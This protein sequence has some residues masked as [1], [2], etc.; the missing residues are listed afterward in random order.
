M[1]KMYDVVRS[2]RRDVLPVVLCLAIF[3]LRG[4]SAQSSGL[5]ETQVSNIIRQDIN[6][7]QQ[8]GQEFAANFL[9]DLAPLLILFGDQVVRQYMAQSQDWPDHLIF[10]MGPLGVVAALTGAVRIC[11]YKFLRGAIGRRAGNRANGS[12]GTYICNIGGCI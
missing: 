1:A 5:N 8:L 4:T 3:Y 12:V 2:H 6:E 7:I 11:G 10:A 9:T